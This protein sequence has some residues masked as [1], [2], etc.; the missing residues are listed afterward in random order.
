VM[1]LAV[2]GIL[3]RLLFAP[4]SRTASYRLLVGSMIALLAGDIGYA[5]VLAKGTYLAGT[6]IAVGWLAS[7]VLL[8]CAALHPSMRSVSE[9]VARGEEQFTRGRMRFLGALTLTPLIAFLVAT[10]FGESVD[11]SEIVFG[12]TL[13]F[14]LVFGRM[15]GLLRDAEEN[16]AA[17]TDRQRERGLLLDRATQ[18]AEEERS[19]LAAEL[20]DGPIQ[21]LAGLDIRLERAMLKLEHGDPVASAKIISDAGVRVAQEIQQL[22]RLMME[23]SPPVLAERG[24]VSALRDH[25]ATVTA[26]TGMAVEVEA[27]E[28]IRLEPSLETSL[29]RVGQEALANVV[30]HARA[31]HVWIWLGVDDETAELDIRDD[32]VGFDPSAAAREAGQH[33]FGLVAMRERVCMRGGSF[34]VRSAPGRG[35]LV[36]ARVPVEPSEVSA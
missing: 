17:L 34:E 32:G 25:S 26:G 23:L 15:S 22:R 28:G 21:N 7:Y 3:A 13:L 9:H 1:D 35:T 29:Y 2:I 24:L 33:H 8:G 18:A 14:V 12:S 6:P 5:V 20:H 36:R 10:A 16:R 19:R 27:R 11:M 31:E 4:G 30:K